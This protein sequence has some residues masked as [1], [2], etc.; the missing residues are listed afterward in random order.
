MIIMMTRLRWFRHVESETDEDYWVK[1]GMTLEVDG[2]RWRGRPRKTWWN[3][4]QN[5]ILKVLSCLERVHSIGIIR[6]GKS[7]GQPANPR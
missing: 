6:D 2:T 3:C 7:S 1:H 5:L 4:V